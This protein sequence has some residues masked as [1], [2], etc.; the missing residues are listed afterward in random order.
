MNH[1]HPEVAPDR[2]DSTTIARD[3]VGNSPMPSPST[4]KISNNPRLVVSNNAPGNS[5]RSSSIPSSKIQKLSCAIQALKCSSRADDSPDNGE[6]DHHHRHPGYRQ[7]QERY[8]QSM[9]E[10]NHR[11][12]QQHQ[13][14]PNYYLSS[15]E[16]DHEIAAYLHH[17]VNGMT[18]L[19]KNSANHLQLQQQQQQERP[20]QPQRP[21]S[22]LVQL[23]GD[24]AD[25]ECAEALEAS[26]SEGEGAARKDGG[27][28]PEADPEGDCDVASELDQGF[29]ATE[30][31]RI[32]GPPAYS[33]APEIFSDDTQDEDDDEA[34]MHHSPKRPVS[35]EE[36]EDAPQGICINDVHPAGATEALSPIA[37]HRRGGD[38]TEREESSDTPTTCNR[39]IAT[40][41]V[42]PL[43]SIQNQ[44][45]CSGDERGNVDNYCKDGD[46]G[47]PPRGILHQ[48]LSL[49]D[50][51]SPDDDDDDDD[52]PTKT[53]DAGAATLAELSNSDACSFHQPCS[54][55]TA[56]TSHAFLQLPDMGE[57]TGGALIHQEMKVENNECR[58]IVRKRSNGP[59]VQSNTEQH[60]VA[61]DDTSFCTV[62][63]FTVTSTAPQ[64]TSMQSR[65]KQQLISNHKK[66]RKAGTP[67]SIPHAFFWKTH[68]NVTF[69][70]Y[71]FQQP[72]P[73][74]RRVVP[75]LERVSSIDTFS[76]FDRHIQ[77]TVSSSPAGSTASSSEEE[78]I[79][80]KEHKT[81][82]STESTGEGN[83][84][85]FSPYIHPSAVRRIWIDSQLEE[86]RQQSQSIETEVGEQTVR[87]MVTSITSF[88]NQNIHAVL[89]RV[90]SG[91]S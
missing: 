52:S 31:D 41:N 4:K 7:L 66:S 55:E 68:P 42:T 40:P 2:K 73:R 64:P 91:H 77:P 63:S 45:R 82:Q 24:F 43:D 12:E 69:K 88:A 50:A 11:P 84:D 13:Q 67:K 71:H 1:P 57:T 10:R 16:L 3:D 19:S 72:K 54:T 26:W 78:I 36:E 70:S 44:Y 61:S 58:M 29:V 76:T 14:Q 74:I 21:H 89:S 35:I 59:F 20:Q 83:V 79:M 90:P 49:G 47:K 48:S 60:T 85:T 23:L 86:Q 75:N 39:S 33:C 46:H 18:T 17:G 37:K 34:S 65:E 87:N 27:E 80:L 62:S 30:L 38:D 51:L 53:R 6:P 5:N 28:A 22:R 15:T 25:F 81:S 9:M 32:I 56:T 8:E